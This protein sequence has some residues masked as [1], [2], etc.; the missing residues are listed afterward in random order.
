MT[1]KKVKIPSHLK[2]IREKLIRE[3][4]AAAND[5][6]LREQAEQAQREMSRLTLEDWLRRFDI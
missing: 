2:A 4:E 5:P 1:E 3:L 6:E